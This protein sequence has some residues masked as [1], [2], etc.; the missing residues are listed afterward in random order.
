MDTLSL[1]GRHIKMK[2]EKFI[3]KILYFF[4][5]NSYFDFLLLLFLIIYEI[6]YFIIII[7]IYKISLDYLADRGGGGIG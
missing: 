6:L 4:S 1:K 2:P 5:L 3:Y 7:Y